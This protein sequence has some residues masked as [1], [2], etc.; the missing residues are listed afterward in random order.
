MIRILFIALLTIFSAGLFSQQ[1]DKDI[2]NNMM[3]ESR[4]DSIYYIYSNQEFKKA[5]VKTIQKGSLTNP[6][7]F[8]KTLGEVKEG[9]TEKKERTYGFDR[10][11]KEY[12]PGLNGW[13][14]TISGMI[15]VFTGLMLIAIVIHIF[16]Y[17]FSGQTMKQSVLKHRTPV[18]KKPAVLVED[19][20]DDHVIAIAAAI[21]IYKKLYLVNS[22][23]SLTC[24]TNDN[25]FWK[26]MY[27]FNK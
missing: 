25:Y 20:P 6:K 22:I 5:V 13:T 27:Q 23:S 26:S 14:I 7:I 12:A 2:K 18:E 15:V 21:E 19:I 1:S 8:L 24:K 11:S 17:F 10:I 9:K 4:N 16:N 3:E